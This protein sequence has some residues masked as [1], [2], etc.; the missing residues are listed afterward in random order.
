[1]MNRVY[2]VQQYNGP[3]RWIRIPLKITCECVIDRLIKELQNQYGPAFVGLYWGDNY[4][5]IYL[6]PIPNL[7][8]QIPLIMLLAGIIGGIVVDRYLSSST[9]EGYS[10]YFN[11]YNPPGT[12][13]LTFSQILKIGALVIIFGI[14][15]YIIVNAYA[16][17]K[18]AEKLSPEEVIPLRYIKEHV[19]EPVGKGVKYVIE[20][21]S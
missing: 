3:V 11:P 7:Q 21:V 5:V 16:S 12:G 13:E 15:A 19:V 14:G 1:M 17:L 20:K 6:K 4:I 9:Q 18:R 2:L 10:S 8:W